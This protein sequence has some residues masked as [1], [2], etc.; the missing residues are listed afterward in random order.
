MSR[1]SVDWRRSRRCDSNTCVEVAS[2]GAAVAMR[3]G[4]DPDG[5]ILVF[6]R[7]D[8]AAFVAGLRAGDFD[9]DR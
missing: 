1:L 6:S 8:W 9:A 7:D 2:A 4:K 3:D 5:V